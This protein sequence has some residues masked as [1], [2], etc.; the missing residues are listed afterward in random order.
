MPT[1]PLK[2]NYIAFAGMTTLIYKL[3]SSRSLLTFIENQLIHYM[4]LLKDSI[5]FIYALIL[6]PKGTHPSTALPELCLLVYLKT[7]HMIG[8][9]WLWAKAH[10]RFCSNIKFR[11]QSFISSLAQ[12][13][14][15]HQKREKHMATGTI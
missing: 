2:L 1:L 9:I 4:V 6:H 8:L 11:E 13:W 3:R 7:H 10:S 5:I 12:K 15:G 14:S